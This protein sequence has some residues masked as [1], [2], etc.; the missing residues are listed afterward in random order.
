MLESSKESDIQGEII[1][2][3]A[4]GEASLVAVGVPWLFPTKRIRRLR[5]KCDEG[6]ESFL[7]LNLVAVKTQDLVI[8]QQELIDSVVG[9][10]M[11]LKSVSLPAITPLER[12][13]MNLVFFLGIF[14][15][16]YAT[17]SVFHVL[18]LSGWTAGG[19]LGGLN[20]L[21]LATLS[22]DEHR[23]MSFAAALGREI[24]RRGGSSLGGSNNL[25]VCPTGG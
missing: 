21:C 18:P 20:S 14:A 8:F 5:S 22:T 2:V 24:D 12:H 23:R 7:R 13:G 16:C 6:L 11:P 17:A 19:I 25:Q 3:L 9:E 15:V 10:H 4:I 1:R